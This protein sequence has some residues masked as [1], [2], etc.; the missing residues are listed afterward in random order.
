MKNVI[1]VIDWFRSDEEVGGFIQQN[2]DVILK[3]VN[4]KDKREF[5]V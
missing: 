5:Y 2:I 3:L 4:Y 1:V